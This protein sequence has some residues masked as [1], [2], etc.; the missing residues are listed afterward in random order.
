MIVVVGSVT[1]GAKIDTFTTIDLTDDTHQPLRKTDHLLIEDV[2]SLTHVMI[3]FD[4]RYAQVSFRPGVTDEETFDVLVPVEHLVRIVSEQRTV[5]LTIEAGRTYAHVRQFRRGQFQ[6]FIH[7]HDVK[8]VKVGVMPRDVSDLVLKVD[9]DDGSSLGLS[10][11]VSSG[12]SPLDSG[13]LD[14][15]GIVTYECSEDKVGGGLSA[16]LT[17]IVVEVNCHIL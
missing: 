9:G 10:L 3:V 17:L 12:S 13:L 11:N 2:R 15:F 4:R 7:V 8:K 1:H 6:K 14:T 5:V 16:E